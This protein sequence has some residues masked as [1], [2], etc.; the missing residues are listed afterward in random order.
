VSALSFLQKEGYIEFTEDVNLPSKLM[1]VVQRDDLYKLQVR[2]AQVDRFVKLVLRSYTGVFTEYVAISES[3][4]AKKLEVKVE[5]VIEF[6]KNL[7]KAK[8]ID[9]I[10]QRSKPLITYTEERLERRSLVISKA[11]YEERQLR[12]KTRIEKALQYAEETHRCRSQILL[13]YFGETDAP[14]CGKCDYCRRKTDLGLSIA[15]LAG[16]RKQILSVLHEDFV[17][18][19]YVT[20]LCETDDTVVINILRSLVA[21]GTIMSDGLGRFCQKKT[22]TN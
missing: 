16:V 11:N 20:S 14:L 8:V 15:E 6:L 12:M 19:K 22:E 17:D 21:D 18:L 10:P 3:M 13:A 1:F 2:S 9:Y 4:L 5:L 7:R